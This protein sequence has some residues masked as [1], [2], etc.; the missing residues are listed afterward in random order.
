MLTE[1]TGGNRNREEKDKAVVERGISREDQEILLYQT[2]CTHIKSNVFPNSLLIYAFIKH[3][4]YFS[5]NGMH[6]KVLHQA[7]S[8]PCL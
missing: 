2:G 6:H 1:Q 7:T 5:T 4:F 8:V 3:G